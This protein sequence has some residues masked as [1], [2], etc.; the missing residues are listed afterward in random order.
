MAIQLLLA[1]A[2]SGKT[3]HC[4]ERIQTA[5]RDKP[6]AAIWVILPNAANVA[7]F[8]RRLARAG[9]AMGV[10]LGTFY[11]L[12]QE[13]LA[14]NGQLVARLD[15]PVLYRFL[16]DIAAQLH[17]DGRLD[18]FAGIHA[19]PGFA[20]ALHN[21][22]QELKRARLTPEKLAD[23]VKGRG[24]RLEELALL[25][26]AYQHRLLASNW[27]DG[28]G[29]GWL[30]TL[31]LEGNAALARG[32]R[33]LVVDGFDEF[34]PTQLLVL[35]LLAARAQETL[36]TLT[37]DPSTSLRSAH[38]GGDLGRQGE[39]LAHRRFMR[40]RAALASSLT[41]SVPLSPLLERSSVPGEGR[42]GRGSGVRRLEPA[43]FQPASDRL[44]ADGRVEF[45]EA[46]NR[47]EEIRAALRWLKARIVRDQ[48][49]PGEV[50]LLAREIEPYRAFIEEV[51]A[52]FGMPVHLQ[53]GANLAA[54]PAIAALLNLLALELQD[55]PRRRVVDAWRTP[56]ADW[57]ALG[58]ERGDHRG[59][60]LGR[61]ERLDAAARWGQVVAGYDQW[62]DTLTRLARAQP[63]PELDEESA[64]L[65]APTGT[66][67]AAL[68]RKFRQFAARVTP[69]PRATT[70]V[71]ATWLE[72]L[73]GDDPELLSE[74]QTE[75]DTSLRIVACAS[76]EPATRARDV[77]ALREFKNILRALVFAQTALGPARGAEYTF[78]EF[79]NE[80]RGA[81]EAATYAVPPPDESQTI[82]AAS[83]LAARGLSF[84]AVALVGLAEGEFPRAPVEDP[85]LTEAD[86]AMLGLPLRISGDE[87]TFFYEAVTR[88]T[89]KL[90][91]TR[92]YLADDGQPWEPSPYWEHVRQLVDAPVGRVR[93][94]DALPVEDAA[95]AVELRLT[96]L[97]HSH[98]PILANS[99]GAWEYGGQAGEVVLAARLAAQP[100]GPY[101]GD[102][103]ALQMRLE[104]DYPAMRPWS[105]SRL[106]TFGTCPFAYFAAYALGLEPRPP[107]EAGYD[108]RQLGTMYHAILETLFRTA[109]D[110]TDLSALLAALPAI[111]N[112]VFDAAPETYGFRPTALWQRQRAELEAILADTIR[113]L[114]EASAGWRPLYFELAFG[115]PPPLLL[116]G[117]G[118]GGGAPPSAT[119]EGR[120]EGVPPLVLRGDGGEIQLRGY[121][122]RVDVNA[123][124]DLRVVDYKAGSSSISRADLDQ[125]KR[126]QLALY[127]LALRDALQVGAPAAGL[128]WHI[129]SAKAS[130][131]KLEKYPGG[132]DAALQTATAHSLSHASRVR[133]GDFAP[134]PPDGGCPDW[135][136]ASAFCWRYRPKR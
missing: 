103:S 28:E 101:E 27:A 23:A 99:V 96:P 79:W 104:R 100:R 60:D 37:G 53:Q 115:P 56:Y 44:P 20:H 48:C 109:A 77:A 125:G 105:A 131:L 81:V 31:A 126:L 87:V 120:G 114:H 65:V 58:I 18:F 54:N 42:G 130:S 94:D 21:S 39:R 72:A 85:F 38:P 118:R 74:W 40:A 82:L 62:Q 106:E 122:D 102:L 117:E 67:A 86:R 36:I 84:R 66:H 51:A 112:E 88:A 10:W 30:A 33:L 124:G 26:A 24:A 43:L 90:L 121:I 64:P 132:V 134:H 11:A 61:A 63:A 133:A 15:E 80:L 55:W 47:A 29:Q 136:P 69:P 32:W 70:R 119:G 5:R 49:A 116:T 22:I 16:R 13:L 14:E 108:V 4:I 46:P 110:P 34:N 128:Y 50:A 83:V 35:R 129:G 107:V 91:L 78:A 9:G 45:L 12:Y 17:A 3:Q 2:A 6:L 19:K 68:W 97:P 95:S 25:Y 7:A 111:A 52:E 76:A 41:P 93:L 123:A 71:Y 98:T 89:D 8:R 73:I 59:G 113:A 92:P 57:T 75:S 1:P 135:C 127:A